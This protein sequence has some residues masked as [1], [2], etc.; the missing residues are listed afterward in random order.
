MGRVKA[1]LKFSLLLPVIFLGYSILL[2]I[3]LN[4]INPPVSAFMHSKSIN[5]VFLMQNDYKHEW[6]S[7][8][9]VAYYFPLAVVAS[10]DQNF[11]WHFGFDYAQIEK[12]MNEIKR[13]RR[14]RGASTITQQLAK[15]LFLWSDQ[16]YVRK[17]VEAYYTVLL[18]TFLSKRR[19]LEIY[20]NTVELGKN[21]YGIEAASKFYFN[22]T[23]GKL[24]IYQAALMAS[25]LPNP[26][27]RNPARPSS[28]MLGRESAIIRQMNQLGGKN[29]IQPNL[30]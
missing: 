6:K 13:G 19:I 24:N 23:S 17:G 29:F 3:S 4:W 28:Y 9:E 12:A 30:R 1:V 14:F 27:K 2:V 25:V 5:Y 20:I 21:I 8:D 18:E 7:I 11:F 22:K 15:N 10:E 16:S 26:T